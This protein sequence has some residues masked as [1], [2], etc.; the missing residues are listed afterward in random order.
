[1]VE[2]FVCKTLKLPGLHLRGGTRTSTQHLEEQRGFTHG[3]EQRELRES[4][5]EQEVRMQN[6]LETGKHFYFLE[7]VYHGYSCLHV[8]IINL[9]PR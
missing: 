7:N 2:T 4:T 1:M 3:E 9:V 6:L 5:D 8:H